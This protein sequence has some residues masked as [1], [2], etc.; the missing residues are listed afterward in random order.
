MFLVADFKAEIR[1]TDAENTVQKLQ[2]EVDKLEG[3]GWLRF[4]RCQIYT[5]STSEDVLVTLSYTNMMFNRC[6][7]LRVSADGKGWVWV[8]DGWM[9]W[10]IKTKKTDN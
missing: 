3:K 9:G 4:V 6:T 7:C 8:C 1:C 2:K 10:D 5:D